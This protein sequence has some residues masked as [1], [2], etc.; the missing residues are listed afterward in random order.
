ML[1]TLML[2]A[3]AQDTDRVA[4]LVQE[5]RERTRVAPRCGATARRDD[6]IVV[7]ANREADR[8]YRVPFVEVRAADSVPM[9]TAALLDEHRPPCGEGAFLVRCG[10]AGVSATL[11]FGA[12]AGSGTVHVETERKRAP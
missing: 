7:C 10:K 11:T 5:H 6:E 9:R 12:G 2:L 4:A 1:L 8:R 3:A